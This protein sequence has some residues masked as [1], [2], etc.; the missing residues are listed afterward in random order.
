MK[1][2]SLGQWG[3]WIAEYLIQN[4][5][6]K[7]RDTIVYLS[8]HWWGFDLWRYKPDYWAGYDWRLFL[9]FVEFRRCRPFYVS[10][11]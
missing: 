7:R 9:G 10:G 3:L 2:E 5:E 8:R 1:I 11:M 4:G 6:R